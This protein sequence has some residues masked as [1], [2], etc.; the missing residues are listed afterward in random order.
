[1][2]TSCALRLHVMVEI[3]NGSETTTRSHEANRP[4]R[5]Q[6]PTDIQRN[7]LAS[8]LTPKRREGPGYRLVLHQ[9][10]P[11]RRSHFRPVHDR[12]CIHTRRIC[13]LLLFEE[14]PDKQ[15]SNA[16]FRD[17]Y[18]YTNPL[19]C[20]HRVEAE[21]LARNGDMSAGEPSTFKAG[22]RRLQRRVELSQKLNGV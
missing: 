5:V 13:R 8:R 9:R 6:G 20:K 14:L 10:L 22:L 3:T 18:W 17:Y 21:T 16:I 19:G 7:T 12:Q 11:D 4:T 15:I 1:M 2:S